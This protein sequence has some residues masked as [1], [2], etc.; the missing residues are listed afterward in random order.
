VTSCTSRTQDGPYDPRRYCCGDF[1]PTT[2]ASVKA[3]H[4]W[5]GVSS[6]GVVGDST[7]AVS[8]A[9]AGATLESRVGLQFVVG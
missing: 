4:T 7:W 2:K 9:A 6:D 8:L 5:G 3:F 1:G